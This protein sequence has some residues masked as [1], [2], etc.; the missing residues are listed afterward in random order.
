MMR[1]ACETA[2]THQIFIFSARVAQF[3][4][5]HAL[6]CSYGGFP[7]IHQNEL[8]DITMELMSEVCHNVGTEPSLQPIIDEHVLQIKKMVPSLMLQRITSGVMTDNAHLLI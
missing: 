5:E 2:G 6:S 7:S 3:S 1:F 4:V 8:R